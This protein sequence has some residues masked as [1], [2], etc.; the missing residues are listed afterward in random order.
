MSIS[1]NAAYNFVGA[2]LPSVLTLVTVP[3]YLD[4][5]GV[6]RYGVLTLCWVLLGYASYLDL[7]LGPAL[8]RSIASKQDH[9]GADAS[10]YFWNSVWLSLVFGGLGAMIIYA[11]TLLYFGGM[12]NV[13]TTFRGEVAGAAPF[14]AAIV[15]VMLLGGPMGG[16]LQGRERFLAGNLIGV[17]TNSLLAVLP[18]LLAYLWR[19]DLAGLVVGALAA[20]V[21]PVPLAFWICKQAVPLTA[22][23]KLDPKIAKELLRFGGWMSLTAL[24]IG[25]LN[26]ADRLLIGSAIG[27]AAVAAY[28]IPYGLVS[29]V[30]II[31]HSLGSAL[32]PR[33]AYVDEKERVRL[34]TSSIQAVAAIVTP[35]SVALL[36]IMEPFFTIWI[37]P[38]LTP[39]SA[40]VGY[41]LTTGFWIYCVGYPAFSMLQAMGRPDLV[42]KLHWAETFP[43]LAAIFAGAWFFGL[44]GAAFVVTVRFAIETLL[45]FRLAR[46]PVSSVKFLVLPLALVMGSAVAAAGLSGTLRYGV[47]AGSLVA[48]IV[49]SAFHVPDVLRPYVQ[50]LGS[51]LPV[52]AGRRS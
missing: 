46:V 40:P 47:L 48:S 1:R 27:A 29:R 24:A 19:A 51:W 4:L 2:A 50:K 20:R 28:A 45:L 13:S 11:A 8:A 15:P 42:S 39:I 17:L 18:L 9:E 25:I 23:E 37:G 35:M 30:I 21:L 14:I 3:L 52:R 44:S 43:Y 32:F 41:F 5:V 22:P 34:L 33:F 38:E 12:A 49:W 36:A 16:A 31:P 26:T 10:T 7:G 6:E